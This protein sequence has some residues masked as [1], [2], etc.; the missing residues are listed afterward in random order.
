MA[1]INKILKWIWILIVLISFGCDEKEIL[2]VNNEIVND[3]IKASS[4]NIRFDNPEDGPNNW[5]FRK[6]AI[7][8]FLKSEKINVIGMQEVLYNQFNYLKSRLTDYESVGVGREDGATRGEYAPVFYQKDMFTLLDSGTF[9][10]SETPAVPSIGWDAVLER[11]CT[12][13][14]LRDNRN[15][16]EIH[17]YNTHFDHVGDEARIRS[18]RL[19]VDSIASKSQGQWVILTGDLNAEPNS[20]SYEVFLDAG[21]DDSFE[22]KVRF[23]PVGTLNGFNTNGSYLRRIDFV[24][25]KGFSSKLYEN[26]NLI[27]NNNFLSDHFPVIVLLEYRPIK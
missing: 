26:N 8:A 22:S 21:L 7:V 10:L 27:V 5:H 2:P 16:R 6:S 23:G 11:I 14:I 15:N 18:A 24:F 20:Y 3:Q 9:W 13:V 19:I 12:F 17:C 25:K 1:Q 4:F